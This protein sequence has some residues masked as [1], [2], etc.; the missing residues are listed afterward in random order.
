[1]DRIQVPRGGVTPPL[2]ML[3]RVEIRVEPTNGASAT[4]PRRL[5]FV[6]EATLR[7]RLAAREGEE[8]RDVVVFTMLPDELVSSPCAQSELS[9]YD[10][11][12]RALPI[13]A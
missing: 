6:E 2:Y 11:A 4:I 3:G 1:M 12:G 5:G 7:R 13:G 8:K 9:A 10:A